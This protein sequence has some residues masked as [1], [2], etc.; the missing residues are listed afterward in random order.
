MVGGE[1][2]AN[3]DIIKNRLEFRKAALNNLYDAYKA[4]AAGQVQ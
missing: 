4:L 3:A 1:T 2:V